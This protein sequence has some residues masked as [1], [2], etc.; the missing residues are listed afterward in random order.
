[1]V[2]R[3]TLEACMG[4]IS[5]LLTC[6]LVAIVVIYALA[7]IGEPQSVWLVCDILSLCETTQQ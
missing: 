2:S 1:M 7:Q 4:Y 5:L 3:E 6:V